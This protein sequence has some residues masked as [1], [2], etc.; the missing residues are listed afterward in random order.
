MAK[1]NVDLTQDTADSIDR[2]RDVAPGWYKCALDNVYD[3][4]KTGATVFEYKVL[5]GKYRGAKVFD[6]I[7]DP[8]WATNENATAMIMR[9]VKLLGNR[10]GLLK[11]DAYG[12]QKELDFMDAIGQTVVVQVEHRKYVDAQGNDKEIDSVKFDGVYPLDHEKIPEP[13]RKELQLP[14]AKKK[15]GA[16]AATTADASSGSKRPPLSPAGQAATQATPPPAVDVDVS[17]L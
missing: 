8:T 2:G 13:V 15:E 4:T 14:P 7:S 10:L 12:Q 16:A 11:A 3:D 9:R 5:E 17:D 1:F 6:R